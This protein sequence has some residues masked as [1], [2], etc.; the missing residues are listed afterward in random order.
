MLYYDRFL[1]HYQAALKLNYYND[2]MVDKLKAS[3]MRKFG[4]HYMKLVLALERRA[5]LSLSKIAVYKFRL[6]T[7]YI[8]IHYA[9]CDSHYMLRSYLQYYYQHNKN[10]L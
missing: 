8:Y 7:Y 5:R 3:F 1:G 10:V 9:G 4:K 6:N 2:L